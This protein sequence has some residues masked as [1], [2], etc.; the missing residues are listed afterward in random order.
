M[1]KR[2]VKSYSKLSGTNEEET[3]RKEAREGE[4]EDRIGWCLQG[5][6]RR[7][8]QNKEG[9]GGREKAIEGCKVERVESH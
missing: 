5:G 1:R 9:T 7:D 8:D 4:A 6:D 2:G 3:S